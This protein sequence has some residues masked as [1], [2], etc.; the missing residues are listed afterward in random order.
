MK[1]LSKYFFTIPIIFLTF[2]LIYLLGITLKPQITP[3]S[4]NNR[5]LTDLTNTLRLSKLQ[6][7]QLNF[8]DHRNEVEM[9]II[10]QPNH[11]FK[12][13]ISTQ[14]P[15]LSQVAALQKLIKIANI[16]GKELSFVDLSS[17]RPYATF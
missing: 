10:D 3:Y 13:I 5:Y 14:L 16:E 11:S 12:T 17:R 6:Y 2:Q 8:F 1:Y 9:I 4:D 7:Q 15:P